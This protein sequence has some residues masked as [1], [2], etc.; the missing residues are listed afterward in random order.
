MLQPMQTI[1]S[2]QGL[3]DRRPASVLVDIAA[4]CQIDTDRA[5]IA[6]RSMSRQYREHMMAESM[7]AMEAE[8]EARAEHLRL[9]AQ[10]RAD[11]KL[12]YEAAEA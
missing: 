5:R 3:N 11:C 7:A 6:L 12:S 9:A 4:L 2:L 8:G 10:Y 1:P